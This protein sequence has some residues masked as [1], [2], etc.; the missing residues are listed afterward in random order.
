M[1]NEKREVGSKPLIGKVE[2]VTRIGYFLRMF[3]IDELP[4]LLNVFR[5]E[6]S[7]VGPRPSV[8][9]QLTLMS[10]EEKR[11][12]SVLPGLTGLAQVS[13]NI[14][15]TWQE[16]YVLDLKYVDNIS[17][18]NDIRIFYRT[19]ILI[20]TGEKQYKHKNLRITKK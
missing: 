9:K 4:Q 17:F 6:M 19:A 10:E 16:R 14:H 18:R 13:G 1:T 8:K 20:L 7:L 12:Y 3:K 5:G 2:G 15:I 11:R